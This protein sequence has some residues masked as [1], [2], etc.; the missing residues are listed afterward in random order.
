LMRL[1]PLRV[2]RCRMA[3]SVVISFGCFF[4]FGIR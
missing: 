1:W 2:N 3:S 4:F